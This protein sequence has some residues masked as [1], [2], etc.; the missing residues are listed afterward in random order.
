MDHNYEDK[1]IYPPPS[2]KKAKLLPT[3]CM[4]MNQGHEEDLVLGGRDSKKGEAP[5]VRNLAC[6][7]PVQ[8]PQGCGPGEEMCPSPGQDFFFF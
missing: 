6:G 5:V 2:A 4:Y 1:I 3:L 8:R 7:G